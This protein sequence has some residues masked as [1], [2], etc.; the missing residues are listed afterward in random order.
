[1]IRDGRG[2][3]EDDVL[4][5][6]TSTS[7]SYQNVQKLKDMLKSDRRLSVG[8]LADVCNVAKRTVHRIFTEDLGRRKICEKLVPKVLYEEQKD[9]HWVHSERRY[10]NTAP[11]PNWHYRASFSRGSRR[12]SMDFG[13]TL[14]AVKEAATRCLKEVPVDA[15]KGAFSA[16]KK[17]WRI[18][19]VA[20]E[21]YFEQFQL[22]VPLFAENLFF[23]ELFKLPLGYTLYTIKFNLK[24]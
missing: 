12:N 7:H 2:H 5:G 3:D 8:R 6:R 1:M 20:E 9:C 18:C 24:C 16:L 13:M 19:S 21:R 11:P 10:G 17:R 22:L 4:F 15:F 14:E 23:L